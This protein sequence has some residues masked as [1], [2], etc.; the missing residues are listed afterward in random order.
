MNKILLIF[1][2]EILDAIRDS[3][4]F[5][6]CVVM[7]LVLYPILFAA[8]GYFA[9]SEKNKEAK[10]IYN[11]GIINESLMPDLSS[12]IKETTGINVIK[13]EDSNVM[14]EKNKVEIV[15]EIQDKNTL[16]LFYDGADKESQNALNR[17]NKCLS[18][19]QVSMIKKRI[20][21][22][23]LTEEILKPI[24]VKREN[25]AP[26]EKMGGFLLGILI[27]YMLMIL[28]FQGAM[29][30]AIDITAGEKER[31]TIETLLVTDIKRKEIV[32]GK[33]LVT[34]VLAL[35]ATVSGLIGLV[36]TMQGGFSLFGQLANFSVAI[37]WLSC[38]FMLIVM[39]P[40]LLFFSVI[41]VAIGSAA[42]SVTQATTYAIYCLIIVIALAIF[43][44]VRMTS[45]G[46]GM[47]FIPV[48]NTAVLQQQILIG[49]ADGFNLIITVG[50]SIV[51]AAIAYIIAKHNFE[52]EEILLRS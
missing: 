43:S 1:K 52:Q 45:P 24:T 44:I 42:R 33:V 4:N 31:K 29:R 7:P 2:K 49:T 6:I 26:A 18:E 32:I 30:S 9:Q 3:R 15:I 37:P 39:L 19:Y 8:M 5:V 25:I 20:L 13:G 38:L 23:G 11:V 28:A 50:S 41:L 10:L 35:L 12:Y 17:I 40:I 51:Y 34:F 36:I 22:E 46:T 16:V 48:L 14:F 27:P 21:S 47:F